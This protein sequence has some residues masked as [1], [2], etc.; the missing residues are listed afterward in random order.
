MIINE[1]NINT[2]HSIESGPE[3]TLFLNTCALTPE[4][5]FT[6]LSSVDTKIYSL[7]CEHRI[8]LQNLLENMY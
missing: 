8:F 6:R 3:F 4:V 7:L 5:K 1:L 2:L